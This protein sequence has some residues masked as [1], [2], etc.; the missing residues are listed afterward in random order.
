MLVSYAAI[1][2]QREPTRCYY[3]LCSQIA[4]DTVIYDSINALMSLP[5]RYGQ[6]AF[7]SCLRTFAN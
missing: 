5:V 4:I 3:E 1:E 7:M 2:M 6:H